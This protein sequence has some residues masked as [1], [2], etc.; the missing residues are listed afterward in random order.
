MDG[1]QLINLPNPSEKIEIFQF[2]ANV[3]V[4][5]FGY[6]IFKDILNRYH[7]K[8]LNSDNEYTLARDLN[9]YDKNIQLVDGTGI[10]RPNRAIGL[11]GIININGERIEYYTVDGNFL[12]QIRRGTLGTG[13]PVVHNTGSSVLGQGPEENLPYKDQTYTTVFT[14]DDSTQSFVLDWTPTVNEYG[15]TNEAEIFVAGRRLRSVPIQSFDKTKDQDSP[16]AD[17]TLPVEYAIENNIL[18]LADKPGTNIKI[19]IVRQQGKVWTEN[20]TSLSDSNTQIAKFI[21]EKTISLPR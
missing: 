17:V 7:Y 14:G 18:T 6:R 3:S 5:K 16:D 8:R 11:P 2:A 13:T 19:V 10:P 12:R 21:R 15:T 20:E 9:Y 4:P 1:V